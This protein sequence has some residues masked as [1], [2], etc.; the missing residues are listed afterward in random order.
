[1]TSEFKILAAEVMQSHSETFSKQNKEQIEIVLTPLREKL[2]EF[3]LGLQG[4]QSRPRKNV[5][6]WSSRYAIS[7]RTA[8]R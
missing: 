8:P 7:R 2:G 3:Q 6:P 1:M 5:K 4:A